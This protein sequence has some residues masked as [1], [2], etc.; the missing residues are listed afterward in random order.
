MDLI[1]VIVPVYHVE[2]YL[3]ECVNSLLRQT[4]TDLEIW[5]IDDGSTDGSANLCDEY[6]LL[7]DRIRV[8]HKQNEG[9]GLTRNVG[10]KHA[11]GKYVLFV[12]SDDYIAEDMVEKLYHFASSQQCDVCYCG[13]YRVYAHEITRFSLPYDGHIFEKE[14]II[15]QVLLEMVCTL[16][17][18]KQD[19]YLSMSTCSALFNLESI[20]RYQCRFYSERDFVSEDLLFNIEFLKKAKRVGFINE[21]LYYYRQSSPE[22]LTHQYRQDEMDRQLIQIEKVRKVLATFLDESDYQLRLKRYTL[23]AF[24]TFIQK[25]VYYHQNHPAFQLN[26]CIR[27]WVNHPAI[28]EAIAG[29]PYWQNGR[30]Q[31]LFNG[32]IRYRL[33]WFI[34]YLTR[35]SLFL[36]KRYTK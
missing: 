18:A 14:A 11:T 3:Q 22:S 7:D 29:Y 19:R 36:N 21:P 26:Q 13:H 6:A 10:L 32:M 24:R 25:S 28:R 12:D 5:L 2:K 27:K 34:R 15:H 30:K 16:P 31:A 33:V 20:K 23:A 8:V 4:Y 1:S 35:L 17:N 9:L